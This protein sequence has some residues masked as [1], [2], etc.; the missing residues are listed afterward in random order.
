MSRWK[1]MCLILVLGLGIGSMVPA[2]TAWW[3]A[4]KPV[5]STLNVTKAEPALAKE[6]SSPSPKKVYHFEI[7][8]GM[9]SVVEGRLGAREK[10]IAT[11]IAVQ[12]W[13]KGILD[14]AAKVEFY[15]LDEVQSFF[16][17][18]NEPLWQGQQQ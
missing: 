14:M 6:S 4:E 13:P 9:L 8:H 2:A 12:S 11:G 18:I 15:S 16:D 7:E 5:G 10:V 1:V 17:T 3:Y